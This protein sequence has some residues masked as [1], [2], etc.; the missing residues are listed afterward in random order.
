MPR[1]TREQ[2]DE[3]ALLDALPPELRRSLDERPNFD[4]A[5]PLKDVRRE[6]IA[7]NLLTGMSTTDAV[8]MAGFHRNASWASKLCRHPDIAARVEWMMEQLWAQE[9]ER[10]AQ[11]RAKISYGL[12]AAMTEAEMARA[13]AMQQKRP[14]AAINAI[15]LKAI[16]AGLVRDT[17][18]G[19]RKPVSDMTIEELEQARDAYARD[20]DAGEAGLGDGG[21]EKGGAAP[22]KRTPPLN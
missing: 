16:L 1:K 2:L 13:L 12:F 19:L 6:R 18:E 14:A 7:Q 22:A 10:V 5:R 8:E 21:G 20:A 11:D 15:R 3:E 17:D 4:P 9:M